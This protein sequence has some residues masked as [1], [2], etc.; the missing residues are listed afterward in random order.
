MKTSFADSKKYKKIS[1][2]V[3]SYIKNARHTS[4]A[5]K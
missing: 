3:R 2:N 1:N 5:K 4:R